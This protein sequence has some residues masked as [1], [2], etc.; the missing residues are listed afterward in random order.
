M[1]GGGQL[2]WFFNRFDLTPNPPPT[3]PCFYCPR[4]HIY[5]FRF[6]SVHTSSCFHTFKTPW[7]RAQEGSSRTDQVR[8][9]LRKISVWM[10]LAPDGTTPRQVLHRRALCDYRT[11]LQLVWSWRESHRCEKHPVL[12]M[13]RRCYP[14][15]TEGCSDISVDKCY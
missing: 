6:T 5:T 4:I 12:H 10:P 9:D 1:L 13:C 2:N 14:L 8:K 11:Y 7:T 3:P 15:S